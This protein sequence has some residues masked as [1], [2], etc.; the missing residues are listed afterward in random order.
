MTFTAL[1][2]AALEC[3]APRVCVLCSAPVPAAAPWPIC[4]DCERGLAEFSG[5]ACPGCGRELISEVGLCLRCR[6]RERPYGRV[7]S[8]WPYAGAARQLILAYKFGKRRSLDRFLADRLARALGREYP[9]RPVVPV[10]PR[11]GKLRKEG[12]DQVDRVARLLKRSY[13]IAVLRP[14]ARSG[15]RQQKRLDADARYLNAASSYR[16]AKAGTRVSGSPVLL[17]DVLTTGATLSACAALLKSA[18]AEAVDALAFA[19]D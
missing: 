11:P 2:L 7:V 12:W 4:P 6:E 14:L 10:P 1:R 19:S 8:L 13:G 3:L 15:G 17:D 9:G 18:G 5:Q 16:L